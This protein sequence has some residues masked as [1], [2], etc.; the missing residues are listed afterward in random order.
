MEVKYIYLCKD[1]F[2]SLPKTSTFVSEFK[3][4]K[5]KR[6]ITFIIIT[7][8]I[9][10]VA[11]SQPR[12]T[13]NKETIVMG[14]TQ[15]KQPVTAQYIIT[16]TGNEPLV[17]TNITTSCAC[18]V[19]DWTQMPIAPGQKGTINVAFDAEML[20]HF[21][22]SVGVYSNA[23]P[24]LVYLYFTGEVV[25]QVTDFSHMDL[26][27]IGDILID[28]TELDFPDVHRGQTASITLSIV[29]RSDRPYEPVLMHL[30]QYLETTV[31]PG[32]LLKGERGKMTV[33][34]HTD[35]LPD[36]GLTQ[37]SVY[38]AR[39]AGDKVSDE[40]EIP[41][42]VVLLPNH[43]RLN[44]Q[45]DAAPAIGLTEQSIDLRSKLARRD[46]TSHTVIIA[47]RGT[48]P[49]EIIR[50]QVFNTAVGA[51]LKKNLLQP[52][53]STR[54]KITVDKRLLNKKRHPRILMITNDPAQPKVSIDLV[55]E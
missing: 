11:T 21:H 3:N 20:G 42:S 52:G 46:K 16:N 22:K 10:L 26:H 14:Q 38:L 37:A 13:S 54:L 4:R 41:L 2:V 28:S 23:S 24:A 27:A 17:L 1:F 7:V 29:N 5:M 43:N 6:L 33:T 15:W 19:A 55:I 53:E 35:R 45:G 34:L 50:L 49:L 8:A 48:A 36:L 51:D 30:P 9:A 39:F 47:N 31:E 25:R 44:A 32:V 12:L 18:A 40:N